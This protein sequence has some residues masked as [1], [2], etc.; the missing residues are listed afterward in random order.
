MFA[1]KI[2]NSIAACAVIKVGV[3]TIGPVPQCFIETSLGDGESPNVSSPTNDRPK[4]PQPR[5]T[6]EM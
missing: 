4:L 2:F 6:L 1:S 5:P 3:K